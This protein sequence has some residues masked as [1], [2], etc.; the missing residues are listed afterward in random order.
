MEDG[1]PFPVNKP[2]SDG[3]KPQE[4]AQQIYDKVAKKATRDLFDLISSLSDGQPALVLTY[5]DE[6]HELQEL[7]WVLLR[8][9]SHQDPATGMWYSFMGTQFELHYFAPMPQDNH[10][11]V[12]HRL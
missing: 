1:W 4:M 5:F 6:A 3:V 7:Y 12:L 8:L 9:L 10:W 2:L 11:V